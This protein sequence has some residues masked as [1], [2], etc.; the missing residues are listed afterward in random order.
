MEFN[1][2][3]KRLRSLREGARL[4]QSKLAQEFGVQQPVIAKYEG[5]ITLPSVPVLV[6]YADFFDISIDYLVGR[7][8]KPQGKIY[9]FEPKT[10]ENNAN[11]RE[12]IEMCF[13]PKSSANAKLKEAITKLLEEQ[14]K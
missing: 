11:M 3:S 1:I 7:T 6:K 8:D 10:L 13:D 14:K 9:N 5:A 2:V 12:F 4:S